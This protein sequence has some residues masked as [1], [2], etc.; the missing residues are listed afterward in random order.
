MKIADIP[1]SSRPREKALRLGVASLTDDELISL[2]LGRG[3]KGRS[4]IEIG[5]DLLR[6]HCGLVSLSESE[7][8]SLTR[9]FGVSTAGALALQAT[10]EIGRRV[11]SLSSKR[12][13]MDAEGAYA[14]FRKKMEQ[15]E[16]HLLCLDGHGYLKK[17]ILLFRGSMDAL[18]F[19][20]HQIVKT[21]LVESS[22]GIILVH[23]HPGGICLPSR[24]DVENTYMLSAASKQVGLKFVDHVI[25][26][27]NGYYS[28]R[29]SRSII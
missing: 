2:I 18:P 11:A 3:T 27:E 6:E 1:S 19:N 15:E 17:D 21:A 23:N 20:C 26:G 13:K 28:F 9:Q 10:F 24:V 7:I 22:S 16:L 12:K 4:A 14:I 5:Q 8:G 25:V 29:E